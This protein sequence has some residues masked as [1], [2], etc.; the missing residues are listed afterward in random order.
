MRK[1]L[2]CASCLALLATPVLADVTK[3]DVKALL[4]A[5][6]SEGVIVRYVN[7][8]RPVRYLSSND[9]VELKLAGASDGLLAFLIGP[10]V[11]DSLYPEPP[12]RT[13]S[14]GLYGYYPFYDPW[15]RVPP[16][17]YGVVPFRHSY[18]PHHPYFRSRVFPSRPHAPFFAPRPGVRVPFPQQHHGFQ[19]HHGARGGHVRR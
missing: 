17:G 19:Q 18:F 12:Y 11:T 15:Y 6:A 13:Y 14:Y 7:D 16:Y 8:H 1:L 3:E 4:Q 2:L 10:S 5:G 9:L